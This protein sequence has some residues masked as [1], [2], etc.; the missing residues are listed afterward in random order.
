MPRNLKTLSIG[1]KQRVLE[2]VKSGRKKKDI[3]E[4]FWN[5]SKHIIYHN[6]E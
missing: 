3:A 6:K 4:E 1:E 2:A 5:T